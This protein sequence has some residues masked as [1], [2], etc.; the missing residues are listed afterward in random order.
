MVFVEKGNL[1]KP[2][3]SKHTSY[4]MEFNVEY[5][6]ERSFFLKSVLWDVFTMFM[7]ERKP[8][9]LMILEYSQN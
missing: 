1:I 2:E 9:S 6:Q 4:I 7:A 5:F 8:D 3:N